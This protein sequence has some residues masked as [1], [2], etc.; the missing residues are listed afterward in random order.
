MFLCGGPFTVAVI[1][2]PL[3]FQAVNGLS[4]LG[5]GIRLLPFAIAS[6]IGSVIAAGVAVK[7]KIPPIYLSLGGAAILVVG[8]ALLSTSPATTTIQN[9][10]YGYQTIAG[11]G[12][13]VSLAALIVMT[14]FAVEKRDKC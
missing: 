2:L 12:V 4:A 14:P 5:A 8:F 11:F 9:A 1:E 7:T 6:P 13:G 10:Q 3:R